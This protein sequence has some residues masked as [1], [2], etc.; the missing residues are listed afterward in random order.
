V[1]WYSASGVLRGTKNS[2]GQVWN[3]GNEAG[4]WT[5]I[6]KFHSGSFGSPL[7]TAT[8]ANYGPVLRWQNDTQG[9]LLSTYSFPF[10][11]SKNC[12]DPRF[13]RTSDITYYY[14]TVAIT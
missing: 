12:D 11:Y 13:S 3:Y 5:G 1:P 6:E 2:I 4:Q 7:T 8:N 9:Y 10:G 14:Y